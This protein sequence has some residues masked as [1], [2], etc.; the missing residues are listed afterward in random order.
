MLWVSFA[1]FAPDA[2][3]Q[4][5]AATD[6]AALEA[7]Y[8]ATAGPDWTNSANWLTD[9]PLSDWF[10]VGTNDPN[11]RVTDL[12]LEFN[13]LTGP[14]P[15][16]LGRLA[17]LQSLGLGHNGLTGAI[18]AE[19]GSLEELRFLHLEVNKL[20][21]PLPAELGNLE[22]LSYLSL[23]W[24]ALTGPIPS[25]LGGLENLEKLDLAANAL[26][27]SI[28]ASLENLTRLV[29]LDLSYNWGLSGPLPVGLELASLEK[30]DVW[31]TRSCAPAAWDDGL[32]AVEFRG[33]W[34][35]S[36]PEAT[37]DVAVVHTR[38]AR[39][40]A[41]GDAAIEAE[42]DLLIAETNEAYAA[43]GVRHRV[44]LVHRS[45]VSYD[46][47]G[48]GG[49]DLERLGNPSDGHLDEVHALR[50]RV[51]ADLVHL[52]VGRSERLN[53]CGIAN[54][55]GPFS[56]TVQGCGGINFAHELG[57]NLGLAHDRYTQ[58]GAAGAGP[59]HP[60]H[61]HVNQRGL[62]AGAPESS[63]WFTIMAYHTQCSAAGVGCQGLPRFANPRQRHAGDPLG[64]AFGAGAPGEAGPA[65]AVA[66][67]EIDGARGGGVARP[68][69][70]PPGQPP[71]G[72]GGRAGAADRRGRRGCGDGGRFACVPGSG[73][74]SADLRGDF[75]G[76]V[77]RG[78]FGVG[79]RGDRAAGVGRDGDGDG[80]SDR[81]RG[82]ERVGDA[83]LRGD[84]RGD[85]ARVVHGSP[86]RARGNAGQG[87][88][89]LG[90]SGADRRPAEG[91][92]AD[93]VR[94]DGPGPDG[95][96]DAGQA[97][98][99]A[100]LARGARGGVPGGGAGSAPLDGRVAGEGDHPD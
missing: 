48:H 9:S 77:R 56:L 21:G 60:G 53:I 38:A 32:A 25:T 39:E 14:L 10:G 90:A 54:L 29:N 52:I 40:K 64:V 6:R 93:A 61:G 63:R 16:E 24:N 92:G 45:E 67:L 26:T 44:A 8:H 80:D 36:E 58:Y 49:D 15:A 33:R 31:V 86:A 55:G 22:Y 5:S 75:V 89:F 72:D 35:G 47:S 99:S 85:G 66:V 88:P 51:G 78:G 1:P 83:D 43:S 62:A 13:G 7:L 91:S 41:G 100:G 4:G 11:G 50:D 3:A 94:V 20:T 30:L 17:K 98:A 23:G 42:I 46:E 76:A 68:P 28:P 73:R 81:H 70:Q 96:G 69:W 37:V 27:G 71:A 84:G 95:R 97:P 79:E 18:P 74:R 57:H 19:L 2:A 34:C 82:G 59:A 65:D 12:D 87:S